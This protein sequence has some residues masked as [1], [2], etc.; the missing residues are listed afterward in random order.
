MRRLRS[1]RVLG[2]TLIVS[3]ALGAFFGATEPLF[4]PATRFRIIMATLCLQFLLL[5][6]LVAKLFD[7]LAE[8]RNQ[9][10]AATHIATVRGL[11]ATLEKSLEEGKPLDPATRRAIYRAGDEQFALYDELLGHIHTTAPA[12]LRPPDE[13][14]EDR[15]LE[16]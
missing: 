5:A 13:F 15:L 9:H 2:P 11:W 6:F 10:R 12:S 1:R 4:G 8:L 14:I 7:L 16:A 3:V